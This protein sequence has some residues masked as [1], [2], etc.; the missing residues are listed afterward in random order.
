[1]KAA[2]FNQYGSPKVLQL[3]EVEKPTPKDNEVLVKIHATAVNDYDWSMIRGKPFL[4]RLMFGLLRPRKNIPGMELSGVVVST[5]KKMTSF[6]AGDAVYG[7]ISEHGFGSFAEYICIDEKALTLKPNNMSFE[8]AA[9]IPHAAA[10]ALQGLVDIGQIQN[11]LKILINGAGGGVGTLGLQLA[12]LYCAEVTGVDSGDKLEMMKSIGFDYTIDYQTE[13]FTKSGQRY[14][15][16]LDTK[17]N[18]STFSYLRS[19]KPNGKYVTVGGKLPHLLHAL[20]F[21]RVI[22][23]FSRKRVHIIGLK[24]NKDLNYIN[25]LFE[26]EKIKPIIDGPYPLS[27]AAIAVQR[28]GKGVHR[29]KV[30][31]S[32]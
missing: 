15:L 4:Y 30:V 29:G 21:R 2:V 12:K 5:G 3:Q 22:H 1:M 32:I 16:I 6:K 19:L 8:E 28:F 13:D 23:L 9:S 17:T 25:E 11:G 27:E 18:R 20:F 14:D 26:S 10:L 31:I 7:D 24:T